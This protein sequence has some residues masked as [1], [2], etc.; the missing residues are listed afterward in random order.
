M[1][2]AAL[3]TNTLRR[4]NEYC[5]THKINY[6]QAITYF[7]NQ[8]EQ[9]TDSVI[10]SQDRSRPF[11][12]NGYQPSEEQGH[13]LS[14]LREGSSI[15]I[16]G[17]S[18]TSKTSILSSYAQQM[19]S[20]K[21]GMVFVSSGLFK[22]RARGRFLNNIQICTQFS[23]CYQFSGHLFSNRVQN[24]LRPFDI[25]KVCTVKSVHGIN[26]DK[27][28][29]AVIS[30]LNYF[31]L[32][33]ESVLSR[34][35]VKLPLYIKKS[36]QKDA[37]ACILT[38][39]QEYWDKV[40]KHTK[41]CPVTY[42]MLMKLWFLSNPKLHADVIFIDNYEDLHPLL[43]KVVFAQKSQ[44]IIVGDPLQLLKSQPTFKLDGIPGVKH[45]T[46]NTTYR[47]TKKIADIINYITAHF[48]DSPQE[49]IP[50]DA[51]RSQPN[52][53]HR[54]LQNAVI[55]RS[56]SG[57]LQ[58]IIQAINLDMSF[59]VLDDLQPL[60]QFI[61]ALDSIKRTGA[62]SHPKL[63]R[64]TTEQEV[65]D[66]IETPGG[67]SMREFASITKVYSL[68]TLIKALTLVK[69]QSTENAVWLIGSAKI[70]KSMEF[71]SV[72]LSSDFISKEDSQYTFTDGALI[73]A[74]ATRAKN[75]LD[76]SVC[77]ALKGYV[78]F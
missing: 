35:H 56:Y 70:T 37:E 67:F 36:S 22:E 39:S 48:L 16:E 31:C 20:F 45:I 52:L 64:F 5:E 53:K 76:I 77:S 72:R 21:Q 34:E 4:L 14:F 43:L 12:I 66:F 19:P 46:M 33:D 78:P 60:L 15:I 38:L 1:P 27:L 42:S 75:E 55:C 41:S 47:H 32:T 50:Y 25:E 73:Y 26:R 57:L 44:K 10:I 11:F 68:N 23:L 17:G 59:A 62:S 7:L 69:A 63:A 61:E 9:V 2:S 54:P 18:G 65:Y 24:W 8:S 51:S 74:A 29:K 40:T 58:E 30:T 13:I 28:L 3:T 49:L 71:N 6:D